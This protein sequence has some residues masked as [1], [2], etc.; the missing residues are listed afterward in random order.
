MGKVNT[1]LIRQ[2]HK[3][4]E[5]KKTKTPRASPCSLNAGIEEENEHTQED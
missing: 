5:K 1:S 4:E 2:K 3:V